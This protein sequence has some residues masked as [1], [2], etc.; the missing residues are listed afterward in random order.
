MWEVSNFGQQ[1]IDSVMLTC[2]SLGLL[3]ATGKDSMSLL[4]KAYC[5]K[6]E[7]YRTS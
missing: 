6:L 1:L 3:V 2:G 4:W 5:S 7:Q